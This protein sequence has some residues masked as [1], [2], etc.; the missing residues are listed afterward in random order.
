[1][2]VQHTPSV[3][4]SIERA[5]DSHAHWFLTG[6]RRAA[7]SLSG[8]G[9]ADE[10]LRVEVP[11]TARRGDWIVGVGWDQN[12]WRNGEFPSLEEIDRRFPD[13]PV[14]LTRVDF[15]ALWVNSAALN[16]AGLP[17][18]S[19][20]LRD[21]EMDP[22][23][24][25]VPEPT[26][27]QK[28][29]WL[30]QAQWEFLRGGFTHV[31]EMTFTDELWDLAR[32]LEDRGRLK[33][34][35]EAC[36]FSEGDEGYRQATESALRA[37]RQ[38][39]DHLRGGSVKIFVDGA[40]GSEGAFLSEDYGSGSG[41]GSLLMSRE[42]IERAMRHVWSAGLGVAVHAIGD[43]AAHIVVQAAQAVYGTGTR[44]RLEIEHAQLLRPETLSLMRG[45]EV[46]CHFQPCHWLSDRHWFDDKIPVLKKHAFRWADLEERELP[47]FFGSD[48]PIE[49][50]RLALTVAALEGSA[51]AGIRPLVGDWRRHHSYPDPQFGSGSRTSIDAAGRVIEVFTAGEMIVALS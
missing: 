30:E 7:W 13:Q 21:Q 49:P 25:L 8:L 6:E 41:R 48:S 11:D 12:N 46:V 47:F 17:L 19:A 14:A 40:L 38:T 29:D 36:F 18:R 43:E 42:Q 22:V 15:H 33:I 10:I 37:R 32:E 44:G 39:S 4:T 20:V 23:Q 5:F 51:R 31:R 16:R 28:I 9:A 1:M 27:S 50:A 35:V 2:S 34:F 26:R 24:R 3:L 45:L